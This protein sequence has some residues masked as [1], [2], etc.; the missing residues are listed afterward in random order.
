MFLFFLVLRVTFIV[1]VCE[2]KLQYFPE[3]AYKLLIIK[4]KTLE[5]VH[6]VCCCIKKK[7]NNLNLPEVAGV[8]GLVEVEEDL[9]VDRLL[10]LGTRGGR[11][12]SYAQDVTEALDCWGVSHSQ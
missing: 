2:V 3:A 5:V 7:I 1:F 9:L 12:G 10:E 11:P 4:L 6:K 8:Q